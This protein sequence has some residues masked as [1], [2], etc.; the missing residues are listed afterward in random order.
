VNPLKQ[1]VVP[2]GG[3]VPSFKRCVA[4]RC[5]LGAGAVG[6]A[7]AAAV[8]IVAAARMIRTAAERDI[9]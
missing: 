4:V 8:K 3:V 7:H 2:G 6:E 1:L 5:A 9:V